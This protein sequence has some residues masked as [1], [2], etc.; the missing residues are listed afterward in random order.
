[1][2]SFQSMLEVQNHTGTVDAYFTG[3]SQGLAGRKPDFWGML[4][5][6]A[7]VIIVYGALLCSKC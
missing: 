7:G 1:M 3:E 2:V 6:P 4:A 5:V